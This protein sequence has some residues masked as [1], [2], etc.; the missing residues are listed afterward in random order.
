[1]VPGKTTKG[2]TRRISIRATGRNVS[3]ENGRRQSAKRVRQTLFMLAWVFLILATAIAVFGWQMRANPI[4]HPL[5]QFLCGDDCDDPRTMQRPDETQFSL[6]DMNFAESAGR[7]IL[8]GSITNN[9]DYSQPQP[10]LVIELFDAYGATIKR[11]TVNPPN[12]FKS[13][14]DIP[15]APGQTKAIKYTLDDPGGVAIK[16]A[17]SLKFLN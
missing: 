9:A 6:R 4:E 11:Y 1:M 10:A 17:F 2:I 12:Y 5:I 3:R 13:V 7:L 16:Y 8:T 15:I 14:T